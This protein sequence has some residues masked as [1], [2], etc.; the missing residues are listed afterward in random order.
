M[1]ARAHICIYSA[2]LVS[3]CTRARTRARA[4][5]IIFTTVRKSQPRRP[6]YTTIQRGWR[7]RVRDARDAVQSLGSAFDKSGLVMCYKWRVVVRYVRTPFAKAVSK[8]VRVPPTSSAHQSVAA[9]KPNRPNQHTPNTWVAVS[10]LYS[11]AYK[12][13]ICLTSRVCVGAH[14]RTFPQYL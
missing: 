12:L 13:A 4:T 6:L 11:A 5:L 3:R 14:A 1:L 2:T 9:P 10:L 7:V 8:P